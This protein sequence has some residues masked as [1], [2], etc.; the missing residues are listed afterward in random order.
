MGTGINGNFIL[1]FGRF[2]VSLSY[3]ALIFPLVFA[4]FV[5]T[6]RNKGY[7]GILLSGIGFLPLAAFLVIVPTI[8]GLILYTL[9]ALTILCFTIWKDWFGVK[10]YLC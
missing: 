5:Y 10:L 4:L 7:G 6:Q 9:S 1:F 2:S 3:L 8:T